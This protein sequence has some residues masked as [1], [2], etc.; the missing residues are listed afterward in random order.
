MAEV[1]FWEDAYLRGYLFSFLRQQAQ[2]A[3]KACRRVLVW[4]KKVCDFVSCKTHSTCHECF[5]KQYNGPGC[6]VS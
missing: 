6:R 2:K 3:C 4:D 5:W 1:A